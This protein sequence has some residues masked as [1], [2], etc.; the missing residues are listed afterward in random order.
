MLLP[1]MNRNPYRFGP[2]QTPRGLKLLILLTFLLSL[3]A[4]LFHQIFPQVLKLPSPEQLLSLSTWGIQQGFFWQFLTYF[5]IHPVLH[6]ISFGLLVSLAFSL[7]LTWVVGSAIIERRGVGS[8]M[9]LYFFS[10]LLIGAMVF[11]LQVLFQSPLALAGNAAILYTILIAWIFLYPDAQL[12]LLLSLPLRA[13]WLILSILCANL[14]IDLS[15]GDWIH[16]AAYFFAAIIGYLYP[17]LVWKL[18][19]PFLSLHPL[20]TLLMKISSLGAHSSHSPAYS[21][22]AKIYDFKTGR[23]ILTDDEFLDEMLSKISLHG[24]ESLTWRERFRLRRISKRKKKS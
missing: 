9:R 11:G 7:Y 23:A 2:R 19:S 16:A 24:K 18:H 20:E 1:M 10:G 13:K 14:L 22:R 5:F 8:F 12:L 15:V 21:S 6:G 4:A 3:F 17:V